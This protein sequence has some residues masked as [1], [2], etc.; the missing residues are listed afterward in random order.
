MDPAVP[1]RRFSTVPSRRGSAAPGNWTEG[2]L[3]G[4][5]DFDI[6][7]PRDTWAQIFCATRNID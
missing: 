2:D 1:F 6:R 7:Y 4:Y 5:S 3:P